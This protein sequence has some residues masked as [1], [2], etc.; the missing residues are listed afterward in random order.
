MPTIP[1]GD[2]IALGLV[3]VTA[4]GT[5]ESILKNFTDVDTEAERVTQKFTGKAANI[6]VK[7]PATN[8][9]AIYV[10]K[11]NMN[12]TTGVGVI[13]DIAP[14]GSI[15]IGNGIGNLFSLRDFYIDAVTNGEGAYVSAIKL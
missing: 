7:A 12:T 13:A 1:S 8:T 9:T 6:L 10:G 14:G 11:S 3:T 4:A 15:V 5:P 2:P